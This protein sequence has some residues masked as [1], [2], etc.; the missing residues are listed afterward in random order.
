MQKLEQ[1]IKKNSVFIFN[2]LRVELKRHC[3]MISFV[4]VVVELSF[5]M[6]C[7]IKKNIK[8]TDDFV[9]T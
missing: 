3:H 4:V 1:M 2:K 6:F 7:L 5:M 8:M 9:F